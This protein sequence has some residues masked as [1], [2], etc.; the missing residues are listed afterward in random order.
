MTLR[1][2]AWWCLLTAVGLGALGWFAWSG[3]YLVPLGAAAFLAVILASGL[4]TAAR[5]MPPGTEDGGA[6]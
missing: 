6:S 5:Q 2:A 4:A 1:R 3:A